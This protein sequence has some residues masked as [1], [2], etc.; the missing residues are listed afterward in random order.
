MSE[1][2][3]INF[4]KY[5]RNFINLNENIVI[6]GEYGKIIDKVERCDRMDILFVFL[7]S[8][9]ESYEVLCLGR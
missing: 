1:V 8:F 9:W 4:L 2:Y 5:R 7:I 6:V 3:I